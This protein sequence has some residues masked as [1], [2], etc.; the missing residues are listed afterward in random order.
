M[1]EPLFTH[2]CHC[3]NCQRQTGSAF[4]INLLIEAEFVEVLAGDPAPV[5]VPRDD[6]SAQRIYRCPACQV[7]V[8]SEYGRPEIKFVRA[9]TLDEPSGATPDVHIY[10][11]SKVPWITPPGSVP[12]FEAYYDTKALW[13]AASL[14][15]LQA[16]LAQPGSDA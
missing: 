6:G 5:D 14:E 1:S 4:V 3:L 7:A 8:F 16:A 2:C 10:T 15:R 12:A 11:R 9:G 13:P